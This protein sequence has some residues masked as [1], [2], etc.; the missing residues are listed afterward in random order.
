MYRFIRRVGALKFALIYIA[1]AAALSVGL[2]WLSISMDQ[3][4]HRHDDV[5]HFLDQIVLLSIT[6]IALFILVK[7]VISESR[8]ERKRLEDTLVA[9]DQL[10][11][12]HTQPMWLV[13]P[14]DR[15][16]LDVNETAIARYGWSRDEFLALTADDLQFPPPQTE[17]EL[18]THFQNFL[19]GTRE[20]ITAK[21]HRTR[22]GA[23]FWVELTTHPVHFDGVDMLLV[24]AVDISVQV[25]AARRARKA[26]KHLEDAEELGRF[27]SW[28]WHPGSPIVNASRG[29]LHLLDAPQNQ[30]EL[31]LEVAIDRVHP[32]DRHISRGA[33]RKCLETGS[34][35]AQFRGMLSNGEIRYYREIF[36]RQV[37]NG[38]EYVLMGSIIDETD[39]ILYTQTL[40][41][42]ES[43]LRAMLMGLPVPVLLHEP[44]ET[45]K[46]VVA[47]PAFYCM[48]GIAEGE[49]AS[50]NTLD[51]AGAG[52][53]QQRLLK[54]IFSLNG[55]RTTCARK[56][57]VLLRRSNGSVFRVHLHCTQLQLSERLLVQIV[58]HDVDDEIVLREQLRQA[59]S[60][61]SKLNSKTIKVLEQER[62]LI[63]RELHDDIGQL[64]IAVKTNTR[65]LFNKWPA[66]EPK[67]GEADLISDILEELVT[68]VRDRSLML[69]PPQLDELGLTHAISWEMRRVLGSTAIRSQL[70]DRVST[71]KMPPE[72]TLT[73]FRIFQEAMTNAVRHAD[74]KRLDVII[75]ADER[76]L[77]IIVE[78]DGI[79]FDPQKQIGGLGLVNMQERATL[80]AGI[81]TISSVTGEGT[82][83]EAALP[84]DRKTLA[85][86]P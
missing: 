58:I 18:D 55:N 35:E 50:I 65:S 2:D 82:R 3:N 7:A 39:Q 14:D 33:V 16:I 42:Q 27:G 44:G 78:D 24:T 15:R 66:G 20:H 1:I 23:P 41:R 76:E 62:A 64:L 9:Y 54:E 38:Q 11:K 83:V 19:Q 63:S 59:N 86:V 12:A 75:E 85:Q 6:A 77:K 37:Y 69:R 84:L 52:P 4:D 29:F 60:N 10:F 34:A 70:H 48:L 30:T 53:E 81:L 47:N 56:Q 17:G 13:D 57:V 49:E 72:P 67:P 28:E 5:F 32:E 71:E 40:E 25:E 73:A 45:G 61:L 31:P 26:L 79:G 46:L 36:H 22:A 68:K 21:R 80:V 51:Q 43:D 74:P 8:A